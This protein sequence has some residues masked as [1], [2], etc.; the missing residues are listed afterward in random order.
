MD[1][2]SAAWLAGLFEGEGTIIIAQGKYVKLVIGMCDRDV[3]ERVDALV[4]SPSGIR[5]KKRQ[6]PHHKQQWI[7]YVNRAAA[8][9]ETLRAILPWLGERRRAR[10]LEALDVL[11]NHHPGPIGHQFRSRKHCPRG[12]PYDAENTLINSRGQRS[13]RTCAREACRR[14]EARNVE[15]RRAKAREYRARKKAAT[16]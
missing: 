1:E 16:G 12:H 2:V 7:W 5:P 3:L 15:K 13:C 9:A 11:E 14:Y 6:E 4:P 10:A 8:A